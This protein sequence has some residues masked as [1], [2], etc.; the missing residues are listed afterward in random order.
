MF[1]KVSKHRNFIMGI[2]AL[3]IYIFHLVPQIPVSNL[4]VSLCAWYIKRAGFIG[5]DIFLLLSAFGL[6]H[7]LSKKPV[8][9][10]KSY[11]V[12]LKARLLRIYCV[13]IPV[14]AVISIVDHWGIIKLLKMLV[15]IPQ[16]GE[17]IYVFLWFVP[18]IVLFYL[19]APL[20]WNLYSKISQKKLFTLMVILCYLVVL[21]LLRGVLREDLYAIA[22]RIPVFLLGFS[23]GYSHVFQKTMPKWEF[24]FWMLVLVFGLWRSFHLNQETKP[25]IIP[26]ENALINVLIAPGLVLFLALVSDL[27]CKAKISSLLEKVFALLGMVSFEF[28]CIQE[29]LFGKTEFWEISPLHYCLNFVCTVAAAVAIHYISK[30]I[31]KGIS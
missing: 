31:K 3:W 15:F 11:L 28:Y 13:Y 8:K 17:N 22:N 12:Y 30:G 16:F 21:Y 19:L 4:Y 18:C 1:E 7:S 14:V 29:W 26:A 24:A 25:F 20:Y 23:F 10:I 5:V 9:D 2:A 6:S 27:L